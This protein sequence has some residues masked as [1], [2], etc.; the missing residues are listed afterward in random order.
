MSPWQRGG[1]GQGGQYVNIGRWPYHQ[2]VLGHVGAML[3][4]HR[5]RRPSIPPALRKRFISRQSSSLATDMHLA[6]RKVS[7]AVRD[8][9]KRSS[10]AKLQLFSTISI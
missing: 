9:N 10:E 3:V 8:K 1:S 6:A 7:A 5:T 2:Q 4:R